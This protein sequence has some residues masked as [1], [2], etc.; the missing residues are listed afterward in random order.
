VN[1]FQ[2]DGFEIYTIEQLLQYMLD[3]GHCAMLLGT[4]RM[5][6]DTNTEVSEV[7]TY[8]LAFLTHQVGKSSNK[9]KTQKLQSFPVTTCFSTP[10]LTP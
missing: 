8:R 4:T 5:Q 9:I 10:R 1:L 6:V 2:V 7:R 3:M